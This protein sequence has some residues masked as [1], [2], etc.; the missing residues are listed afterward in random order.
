MAQRCNDPLLAGATDPAPKNNPWDE[1]GP[2][3]VHGVTQVGYGGPFVIR[4]NPI[5]ALVDTVR[6]FCFP[7]SM[8]ADGAGGYDATTDYGQDLG[9]VGT[10]TDTGNPINYASSP[11]IEPP[12]TTVAMNDMPRMAMQGNSPSLISPCS[13]E[14]LDAMTQ[15]L[16]DAAANCDIVGVNLVR[17]LAPI[18]Q[19]TAP[20]HMRPQW[21]ALAANARGIGNSL[22][23]QC[24][25][26]P[27]VS[28]SSLAS[29]QAAKAPN[30]P[31]P[32]TLTET[33]VNMQSFFDPMQGHFDPS[34][35]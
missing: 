16:S 15:K 20:A 6:G 1:Y 8:Q 11:V 2:S 28:S 10:V 22:E 25:Q 12:T 21:A 9:T 19:K 26:R 34:M 3:L 24:N 30:L 33:N 31:S 7:V 18:C 5:G 17:R 13:P 23:R 14:A 29:I 4:S 27:R 32:M 35:I